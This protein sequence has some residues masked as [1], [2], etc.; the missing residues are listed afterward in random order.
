[1]LR[2]QAY[3]IDFAGLVPDHR[4]KANCNLFT[5]RVSC[6]QS[7]KYNKVK[8]SKGRCACV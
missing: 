6:L 5:G 2:V 7:V 8:L 4:S 1:M 3:L